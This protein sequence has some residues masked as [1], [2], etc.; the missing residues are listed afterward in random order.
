[1]EYVRLPFG[2]VTACATY[3]CLMRV[4]LKGLVNVSFYFDNILV[5]SITWDEHLSAIESV[6]R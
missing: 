4:V 3:I 5:H 1:M 6:L 2:L